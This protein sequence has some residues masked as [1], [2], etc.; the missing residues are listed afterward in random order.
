MCHTSGSKGS[1]P[2]NIQA[3]SLALELLLMKEC[4][5][6]QNMQILSYLHYSQVA[7]SFK[8][9]RRIS[10]IEESATHLKSRTGFYRTADPPLL[11]GSG[12]DGV[13]YLCL[14]TSLMQPCGDNLGVQS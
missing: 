4:V 3:C 11:D 5:K 14:V 6:H 10:Y 12:L 7:P 13:N 1:Q 2:H 9:G 8:V